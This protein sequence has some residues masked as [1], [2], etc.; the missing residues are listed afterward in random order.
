MDRQDAKWGDQ[1]KLP[2]DLWCTILMEEV[3]EFAHACLEKDVENAKEEAVQVAALAVQIL[4]SIE[5][6]GLNR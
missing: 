5:A 1:R 6:Y 4:K 2:S 3:G